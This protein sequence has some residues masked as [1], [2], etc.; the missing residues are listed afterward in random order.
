LE[1]GYEV[2]VWDTFSTN[3]KE[4]RNPRASY[5]DI[6]IEKASPDQ[7]KAKFDLFFHIDKD[8]KLDDFVLS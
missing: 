3:S 8:S 4:N 1:K 2:V 5:Y 6:D 7:C